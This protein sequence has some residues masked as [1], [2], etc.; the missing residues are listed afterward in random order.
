[1]F[2]ELAIILF[3]DLT[4]ALALPLLCGWWGEEFGVQSPNAWRSLA[5]TWM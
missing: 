3:I 5:D 1:M 4:V 2:Q